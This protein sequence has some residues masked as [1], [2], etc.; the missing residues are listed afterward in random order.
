MGGGL[1]EDRSET[2]TDEGE[3]Q[4][5]FY[6]N[7]IGTRKDGETIPLIGVLVA[8]TRKL[9]NSMLAPSCGTHEGY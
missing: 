5:T 9:I 8:K 7:G 1:E 2:T 6:Y 4:K 3:P